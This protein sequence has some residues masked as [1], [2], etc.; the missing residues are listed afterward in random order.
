MVLASIYSRGKL[1]LEELVMWLE[2]YQSSHNDKK[3]YYSIC[4]KSNGLNESII[5][6]RSNILILDECTSEDVQSLLT[7]QAKYPSMK[8]IVLTEKKSMLDTIKN[9]FVVHGKNNFIRTLSKVVD[10]CEMTMVE[11][12]TITVNSSEGPLS[13]PYNQIMY[14]ELKQK[15]VVIRLNNG[16]VITSRTLRVSLGDYLED[17]LKE[18]RFLRSHSAFVVNMDYVVKLEKN[19]F[20]MADKELVPIAKTRMSNV[21]PTYRQYVYGNKVINKELNPSVLYYNEHFKQLEYLSKQPIAQCI[22]RVDTDKNGKPN[23]FV[24]MYANELLCALEG[25]TYEEL[26]GAS[27]YQLFKNGDVKWLAYYYDSAYNGNHHHFKS[28]S[29]EIGSNLEIQSYQVEKG[30]CGC[31]LTRIK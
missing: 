16:S 26:M 25:K 7:I 24:F 9:V 6:D 10:S 11:S 31:I 20:L 15:R 14:I 3:F 4:S 5:Q 23:D 21:I 1:N 19:N 8:I 12:D 30:Y 2:E 27:F 22:I 29:R 28:Y 13:I 18:K 17:L